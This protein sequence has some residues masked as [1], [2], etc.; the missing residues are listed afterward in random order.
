[1]KTK[2][3]A[4][5]LTLLS[6][7]LLL[8]LTACGGDNVATAKPPSSP[9]PTAPVVPPTEPVLPSLPP[10]DP[11]EETP[12]PVE[13]P[14]YGTV[15]VGALNLRNMPSTAGD[16]DAVLPKGTVVEILGESSGSWLK[17]SVGGKVG[18]VSSQYITPGG[19]PTTVTPPPEVSVTGRV[20]AS[21]L[22]VRATASTSAEIIGGLKVGDAV[23]IVEELDGWYKIT[24]S[25][26]TGYVSSQYV[27]KD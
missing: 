15:S 13:G 21:S 1:M 22:N 9:S 5:A 23:T 26:Y 17:I 12:E 27:K 2:Y 3:G 24:T 11:P 7:L 19:D 8:M 14:V 6:A 10:T 20:T 18:Y 16:V 4:L 25:K